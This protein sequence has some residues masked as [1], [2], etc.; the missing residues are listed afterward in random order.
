MRHDI[1]IPSLEHGYGALFDDTMELGAFAGL[2][3]VGANF[4]QSVHGVRASA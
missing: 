4:D 1:G 3:L 2:E